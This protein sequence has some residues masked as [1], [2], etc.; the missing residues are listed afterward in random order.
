[1]PGELVGQAPEPQTVLF[2]GPTPLPLPEAWQ[3]L[4]TCRLPGVSR[5]E[6]SDMSSVSE[7]SSSVPCPLELLELSASPSTSATSL[8]GMIGN[9]TLT[10]IWDTSKGDIGKEK[11]CRNVTTLTDTTV[12]SQ[13]T[14]N[15]NST[16]LFY[17]ERTP[18]PEWKGATDQVKSSY[19]N[20]LPTWGKV[21]GPTDKLTQKHLRFPAPGIYAVSVFLVT[22]RQQW[23]GE[24]YVATVPKQQADT[25]I[26]YSHTCLSTSM[27]D[28]YCYRTIVWRET[29]TQGGYSD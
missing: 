8:A 25:T 23:D 24:V 20:F 1:M 27:G 15:L 5:P 22:A 14:F 2:S 19:V 26:P 16:A 18:L 28:W 9:T 21:V 11:G 29:P 7:R 4:S 10:C 12:A 17:C 3:R 6:S 13:T